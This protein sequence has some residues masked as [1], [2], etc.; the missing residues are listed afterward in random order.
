[1]TGRAAWWIRLALLVA[2]FTL[3]TIALGWSA[4]LLVAVVFAMIDPRDRT[5]ARAALAA[6]I[7]WT[8]MIVVSLTGVDGRVAA[9]IGAA[10]GVSTPL[11]ALVTVAF[12]SALAWSGATLGLVVRRLVSSRSGIANRDV[13]EAPRA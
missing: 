10:F 2:A 11:V 5:P 4:P 8:L 3:A 6:A 1:M 9:L 13:A 7:A 12:A